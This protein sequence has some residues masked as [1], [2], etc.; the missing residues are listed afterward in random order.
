LRRYRT[1][2]PGL[3][4]IVSIMAAG[5]CARER[6]APPR[7]LPDEAFR[8]E[9]SAHTVPATMKPGSRT[10]VTVTFKNLGPVPWLDPAS[11]GSQPPQAGAVRLSYSWW[12]P[13]SPLPVNGS[14][15]RVDLPRPLAPGESATVTLVVAAPAE[16]GAYTLQIDLLQELVAWFEAKGAAQLLVPVRVQ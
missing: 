9:W 12:W 14:R 6:P 15:A 1:V 2:W 11:T 10:P 5:S 8:V 7:P 16:P 4:W 3:S 13:R